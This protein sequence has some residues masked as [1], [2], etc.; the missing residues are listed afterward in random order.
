MSGIRIENSKEVISR[1]KKYTQDM[2]TVQSKK[3]ILR[4]S[5]GQ[6]VNRIRKLSAPRSAAPHYYYGKSQKVK[7]LPGNLLKST[8]QWFT[9]NKEYEIGP[10]VLRSLSPEWGRTVSKSSGYYAAMIF[11]TARAYRVRVMEPELG[12]PATF[13]RIERAFARHHKKIAAK[14]DT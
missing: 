5:A 6:L 12:K 10:K 2:T 7:I 3:I 14:H 4:E 13:E 8:R 9:R 1:L 11:G